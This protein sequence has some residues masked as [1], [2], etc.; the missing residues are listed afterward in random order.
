MSI[1]PLNHNVDRITSL[2]LVLPGGGCDF[3]L[4]VVMKTYS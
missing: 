2:G 3:F 4:A 1:K